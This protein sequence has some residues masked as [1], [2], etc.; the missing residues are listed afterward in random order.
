MPV[1][2]QPHVGWVQ[3]NA[4]PYSDSV[5][6]IPQFTVLR[7][8]PTRWGPQS[9]KELRN[10][11]YLTRQAEAALMS[12]YEQARRT[13][14]NFML[15]RIDRAL[16][17]IVRLH[18]AESPK[19][20]VRSAMANAYKVLRNRRQTVVPDT[21]EGCQTEIASSNRGEDVIELKDWLRGTPK[22]TDRQ[23]NLLGL[24]ADDPDAVDLAAL[25]R[26]PVPRM[27]EQISRTRRAARAAYR[28]EVNMV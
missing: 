28:N 25:Y 3:R 7:P 20:Q 2:W 16:D 15:E 23:R 22:V 11:A 6:T 12:L 18:S 21:L 9:E 5:L 13:S 4:L 19:R 26:I 27:R 1:A 10:M 8:R 14:D 24:L 17:E